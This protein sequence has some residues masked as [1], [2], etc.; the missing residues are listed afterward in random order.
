M[1]VC[2]LPSARTKLSQAGGFVVHVRV[3]SG[4]K[5][6]DYKATTTKATLNIMMRVERQTWKGRRKDK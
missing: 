1:C 6:S 4:G 3:S 5:E 2:R